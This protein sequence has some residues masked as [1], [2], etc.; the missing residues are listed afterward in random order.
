MKQSNEIIKSFQNMNQ[1]FAIIALTGR[2]KAGTA[3]VAKL[4]TNK[5]FSDYVTRP[6]NTASHSMSEVREHVIMY[7]YLHHHWRPFVEVNVTSI[8]ISFVIELEC[9]ELK[10]EKKEGRNG[11]INLYDFINKCIGNRDLLLKGILEHLKM[12]DQA[13]CFCGKSGQLVDVYKNEIEKII[14]DIT[15]IENLKK[16]WKEIYEGDFKEQSLRTIIFCYGLFPVLAECLAEELGKNLN[17]TTVFQDYGNNIRAYGRALKL[18]DR[19]KTDEM[20]FSIPKRINQFIKLLRHNSIYDESNVIKKQ[21]FVVV[22]NLKNIFEAYYFRCRYSAFYLMAVSCDDRERERRFES[23]SQYYLTD[24]N[25]N[26]SVAKKIYKRAHR[27]LEN[28]KWD[29]SPT[30]FVSLKKGLKQNI[31][32]NE[33]EMDFVENVFLKNKLREECYHNMTAQFILQDVT[34]CIENSD[35]FLTRDFSV[36]DYMADYELIRSLA[37]IV[38]LILHPGLLTPTK[39]EKCMQIAM[40]AKLN[41]GCLSRQVGAVVTDE[42]YNILSIGWNDAPCGVESCIRRNMFD[43]LRHHDPEAYSDF[44]LQDE[45]FRKYL[46][47]V[48]GEVTEQRKQEMEGLPFAFCFKDIYQDILKQR[49][50]IY[51]RALHGEERALAMCGTERIK[52]GFLFTTSSPCE[53]CA[54]K[55]KEAQIKKIY[56]IERYPGISQMHIINV[57]DKRRRA[58]YEMFVGAVGH[59]YIKFYTSIMPY[60]DELEAIGYSPRIF[61]VNAEK[62]TF[63]YEE[64]DLNS[65]DDMLRKQALYNGQEIQ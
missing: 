22:N 44:E 63:P 41:S 52:D 8:I 29:K 48:N 54:K 11:E 1:E 10:D 60:K 65:E 39:I 38:T 24:L 4:L 59:A 19:E 13:I 18:S 55:A 20:I 16:K 56:Y 12:V 17:F 3:D 42:E 23:R 49:D 32:L 62:K 64:N 25:E 14:T 33:A 21:V 2:V 7:R 5:K 40:T 53:L 50:Q 51:T 27:Y 34:T 9:K 57:G 37:R 28:L 31:G 36:K 43:L 35:I 58:E 47:L 46:K 30:D 45:E 26:L 6:A 61:H 15:D